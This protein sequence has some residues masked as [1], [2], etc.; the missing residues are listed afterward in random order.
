MD[1]CDILKKLMFF[2]T[3]VEALSNIEIRA[4]KKPL[5]R[6]LDDI[7]NMEKE[8]YL[9]QHTYKIYYSQKDQRYR[10]YV[11][12]S[13]GKRKSLTS[14]SKEELEK[15]IVDFY[16][17]KEEAKVLER[18]T[19]ETLYPMFMKYKEKETSSANAHKLNWVW[20]KYYKQ[21]ELVAKYLDEITVA[22]LKEWFLDK[23]ETLHLT[24]KQ[25]KEMKSLLNMLYDYAIDSNLTK[26][27][28]SRNVRNISY[29]KFAV[30]KKKIS[31]EQIYMGEEETSVIELA[32]QQFKK[33][34]NIAYLAI[35]LNFTLGL[36]VGEL[37]ALKI[38]DF[39]E[40]T[41]H[42]QRQEIKKY[43]H[44]E[45]GV[46]QRS[47]Y[48]VVEHTKSLESN[49]EIVLT[50]NAKLFFEL[51]CQINDSRGFHSEYLLLNAQGERMHN[52]AINNTLRRIN[53]KIDTSQ[54]GNHSIR[55]TCISNLAASGLLT[56][57]EI[58]MFAGHK[59]IS[60]TQ[61][62]YIFATEPLEDRASAYETAINEKM[63][64]VNVFKG[65][66]LV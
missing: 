43:V 59:D 47:G 9:A 40:K 63:L 22:F 48:E 26:Y 1:A 16:K 38:T 41:V 53:K 10:T 42:I 54:K 25:F 44:D 60:T 5:D 14:T 46:V 32:L 21:D 11:K 52:D 29:K 36:R 35:C 33:T 18:P 37:V 23:I 8:Y 30:P 4:K 27:N 39:S 3:N 6:V 56:D 34:K 65:V 28:V 2:H 57:E 62:S 19:F 66:Q 64:D 58:R 17:K 61:K 15:K 20:E 12:N 45:N 13:D 7:D 51:I 55:K 50:S 24:N 49:R 31:A